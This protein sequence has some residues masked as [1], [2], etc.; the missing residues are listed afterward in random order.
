MMVDPAEKPIKQQLL[1]LEAQ[2]WLQ[3]GYNSTTGIDQ[4]REQLKAHRTQANINNLVDEMRRQ[5]T[6]RR[7]WMT[8]GGSG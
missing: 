6:R 8:D 7:E 1:E 3:K 2:A 4:L 5:W